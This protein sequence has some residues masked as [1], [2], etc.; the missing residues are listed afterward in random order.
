MRSHLLAGKVYHRRAE[1]AY[2]FEHDV[3]YFALDLDEIDEVA[4]RCR[5]VARNAANL[6]SFRDADHLGR[7]GRRV[8][9]A[10]RGHLVAEGF[11]PDGLR[12]TLITNLRVAGYVFNPVSFYLCRDRR[13]VL[14]VLI[15]EVHN[16]HGERHVYT[17][18]P[19]RQE[20]GSYAAAMRKAF[21]VSPFID[22]AADYRVSVRERPESVAITI[23]DDVEGEELL[24]T[25]VSLRRKRL[26][27]GA[28]LRALVRT[29]L[30]TQKT[31]ALIHW[32]ALQ[33]LR[34]RVPFHHHGDQVGVSALAPRLGRSSRA[35]TAAAARRTVLTAAERVRHGRLTLVLPDGES[36]VVG[37]ARAGAAAEMRIHDDEAFL[38]LLL[39]GEVGAGEAYME[40]LWS[41][42]DLVALLELAAR[43]RDA[44][45]LTSGW[46][47]APRAMASAPAPTEA[48][49]T[50]AP[51]PARG[52]SPRTTTSANDFYRLFLDETMTY[53]SAVFE[54]PGQP[55]ADAQRNKYRLMAER[56]GLR[57]GERVLEIGCGWGRLRPSMR[58]RSS[59]ARCVRLRSRPRSSSWPGAA[60]SRPG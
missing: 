25:G 11:D 3:F 44:L 50:P 29:P 58:R 26:S 47:R 12:I 52:T 60:W 57:G 24:A 48:T 5:L 41:S 53:S 4:R 46:W 28:L 6:F 40:G 56:A 27:D 17:L 54:Y 45:A 20:D 42:P 30:V 8:E 19:D 15:A 36:R 18:A 23:A 39:G 9:D 10:V 55:L 35:V 16:T 38:R 32:H 13:G 49:A 14:E 22:M 34:R 31:T 2:A 7:P 59:A 43:N 1:P 37:D 51:A 21:Y 33:L